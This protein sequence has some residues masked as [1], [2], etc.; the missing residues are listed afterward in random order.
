[1]FEA[2]FFMLTIGAGCGLVLGLAS[3]IFYV[4]EDP[5][6]AKVENSLAGANCGG[7]GY[8]GC[9]AAAKAVV[10]GIAPSNVC[11]VGDLNMAS[12]VAAIMGSDVLMA[13]PSISYNTCEGGNRATTKFNYMGLE[14][15][16]AKAYLYGG[17]KDC[18]VG[19]LGLGD[20]IKACKFNAIYMSE[21]GFPIIKENSCVG[22]GACIEACPKGIIKIW[23]MSEKLLDFHGEYDALAP[24]RQ[25]CPAEINI[26]KYI[27]QIKKRD[28][29]GAVNTIRERNPF[30][31]SCG[32]V[33]P[34]PCETSCRRNVVD[35]PVSINQLKRFVADYEM[36]SGSRIP[37]RMATESGKKVAVI[38]AGPS[39]LA[40]A[41]F[42]RRVGHS[43][44]IFDDMP[45][46]GGMIRYGIPE[47][48]LPK[49]ILEWEIEG[50]L[51]TGI[52]LHS[53]VKLGRDFYIS[54]LIASDFSAIFLGIGA[55]KDY[56][57]KIGARKF[58]GFYSGISFLTKFASY[59]QKVLG[60]QEIPIGKKCVVIGGGN[61][62]ID[63]VRTLVRLGAG[64]VS[65]I[66][67]RTRKEMPANLEEIEAAEKEGVKFIFLTAP[68]E[69]LGNDEGKIIG[70]KCIKMELGEP[71][72]S[73]RRSPVP[74]EGSE[75]IIETDMLIGAIG[76][77]PNVDFKLQ[78][79]KRVQDE[80]ILTRWNTIETIDPKT[81]QTNIPYIFAGGDAAKGASILVSGVADGRKAARSIDLFLNNKEIEPVPN[82]LYGDKIEAT[83]LKSVNGVKKT[84]RTP[85]PELDVKERIKSFVEVDLTLKEEDAQREAERCL[86]CCRICYNKDT[87]N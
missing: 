56:N 52:Q 21:E 64:E 62:A 43:V 44:T 85:M 48:R 11:V 77:G 4:Y 7:C 66:Y 51:K 23:T 3:K 28:Y 2:T 36:N 54:S 14:S 76:Q 80:L 22:C 16:K 75:T 37:I 29:E 6:I 1:M 27:S 59:Q 73:G 34:R 53:N 30:L 40:C 71:D 38:G 50:I 72:A 58:K 20:C 35:A 33:C 31:L 87:L 84:K 17:D 12:K 47:Y 13:E 45:K 26:P 74:I 79:S 67:R 55:W 10:E 32:R 24:C 41:Y 5:R 42:L 81:L 39:G 68:E 9:N 61:T 15:C 25:G 18:K 86:S 60:S 65:L 19:C 8:A 63:C 46:P 82:A 69:V 57:L 70:L 78:E 83:F 49:E